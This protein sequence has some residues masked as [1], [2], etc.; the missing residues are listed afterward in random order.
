M[1]YLSIAEHYEL[2][3]VRK[4]VTGYRVT[5][6]SMSFQVLNMYRSVQIVLDH[7]IR[8]RPEFAAELEAHHDEALRW[9]VE[10]AMGCGNVR[11]AVTLT[12]IMVARCGLRGMRQFG[13]ISV[14][15]MLVFALMP[16]PIRALGRSVVRT[17]RVPKTHFLTGRE[18]TVSQ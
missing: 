17:F 13:I 18:K 9:L 5:G 8:K 16:T 6:T 7:F 2:G 11:H 4:P 3:V 15:R 12:R 10:R 14:V 1:L